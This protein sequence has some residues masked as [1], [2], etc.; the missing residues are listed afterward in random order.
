M[1]ITK[2]AREL[3]DVAGVRGIPLP[4]AWQLLFALLGTMLACSIA[5]A[6]E[7]RQQG[8]A[9]WA[10]VIAKHRLTAHSTVA[11]K[12]CTCSSQCVCGCNNGTTCRCGSTTPREATASSGCTMINGVIVCPNR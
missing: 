9:A 4:P 1:K 7:P 2:T 3:N 8:S 5:H 11:T 10:M 6:T 12:T